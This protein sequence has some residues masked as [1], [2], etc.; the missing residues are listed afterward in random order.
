MKN[1]KNYKNGFTAV[2]TMLALLVVCVALTIVATMYGSMANRA[3][4]M[5]DSMNR[6]R[7]AILLRVD[8][9]VEY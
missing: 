5:L 3:S 8:P 4:G 7:E 1:R 2:E 6:S 9:N